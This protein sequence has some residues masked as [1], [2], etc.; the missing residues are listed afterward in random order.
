MS[1]VLEDDPATPITIGGSTV[2]FTVLESVE[3]PVIVNVAFTL[4]VRDVVESAFLIVIP[5]ITN[6]S[7]VPDAICGV[8]VASTEATLN[9]GVN[10]TVV[11]D[12]VTLNDDTGLSA[13]GVVDIT[14]ATQFE[15]VSA[16]GSTIPA[17]ASCEATH[18]NDKVPDDGI[19]AA[20][21]IVNV[22]LTPS[23]S[24]VALVGGLRRG[25]ELLLTESIV[26]PS[27]Y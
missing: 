3:T 10:V 2:T 25:C 26:S 14:V 23:K 5:L 6:R 1:L 9:T 15:D 8:L 17:L 4:A 12:E 22:K 13:A 16:D 19:N 7:C 18:D 20:V 11:P 21:V 27:I 24:E